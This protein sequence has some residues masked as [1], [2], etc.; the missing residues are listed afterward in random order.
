MSRREDYGDYLHDILDTI[1]KIEEFVDGVDFDNFLRDDKTAFAVIRGLEVIGEAAKN[2]P[3]SARN[4]YPAAPWK[5]ISGMR[6]KL[7]HQYFGVNLQLVWKTVTE[8][9]DPLK[10]VVLQMIADEKSA[11]SKQSKQI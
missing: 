7:I 4:K 5:D 1:H 6:D 11:G 9:L 8:D 3:R 10:A 2:I